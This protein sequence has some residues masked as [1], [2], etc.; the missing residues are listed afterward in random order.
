MSYKEIA[1]TLNTSTKT[2][3]YRIQQALKLLRKELKEFLS[4]ALIFLAA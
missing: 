2:V 3:D 4:F 1:Q